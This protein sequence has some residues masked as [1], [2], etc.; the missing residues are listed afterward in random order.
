MN[1]NAAKKQIH[2]ARSAAGHLIEDS[3]RVGRY[4]FGNVIKLGATVFNQ[5]SVSVPD[6]H[7]YFNGIGVQQGISTFKN[8]NFPGWLKLVES[9]G[10]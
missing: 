3:K 9:K 10:G 6:M 8:G 7:G 5:S 2:T 4:F 1:F